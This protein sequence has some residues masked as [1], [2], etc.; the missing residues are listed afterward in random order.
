MTAYLVY[1]VFTDT[2]VCGNQLA[3]F[4]DARDLPQDKLQAITAEFKFAET[5]FVYPPENP[6]HT[7]RVRIFTPTT[8]I[9]FAGHPIIGT[10]FALRDLGRGDQQTLEL[11][12]GPIR[13]TFDGDAASF[14]TPAALERVATPDP[15][16]V[17]RA[18]GLAPGD[19]RMDTHA[20]VQATLG[21]HFV[22]TELRDRAALAA[23]QPDAAAMR[24]GAARHP[25]GLDFAQFAY[26]RDGSRIDA[27]MFAPLDNI[28]EDPATGSASATLAALL[29]DELGT[30]QTLAILQGED[31]GRPSRIQA[32][33]SGNPVAIT[34]TGQAVP[35]MAGQLTL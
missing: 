23:C 28:P 5:T 1:D 6:D 31:M 16:L 7:A 25:A 4:P 13:C 15:A 32:R 14:T 11:G 12:V 2:P 26:V 17:A 22:I 10:A 34:I 27:R 29:R 20:P 21:L 8:E 35:V 9:P 30:D 33:T 3:I 18:L 19:I 24:E